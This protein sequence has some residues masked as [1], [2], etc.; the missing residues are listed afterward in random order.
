M[1]VEF[2]S[3][4]LYCLC[5]GISALFVFSWTPLFEFIE[6]F[7]C[8]FKLWICVWLFCSVSLGFILAILARQHFYRTGGFGRTYWLVFDSFCAVRP[9]SVGFLCWSC[10]WCEHSRLMWCLEIR[11]G[12]SGVSLGIRKGAVM[13]GSGGITRLNQNTWCTGLAGPWSWI[14][15]K[16]SRARVGRNCAMH[17]FLTTWDWLEGHSEWR[18]PSLASARGRKSSKEEIWT[19]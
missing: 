16:P 8:V 10:I 15:H 3:Q 6:L 12:M 1:P 17:Q 13:V 14:W 18:L 11:A 7:S 2:L 9:E 5:H 4:I 19:Y